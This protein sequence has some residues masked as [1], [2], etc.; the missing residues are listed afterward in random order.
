MA[1]RGLDDRRGILRT[2][3]DGAFSV[4]RFP[5]LPALEPYV[6]WAWVVAWD[7][8]GLPPHRQATLAH[9]SAHLV[10]EDGGVW[11]Y[12]PPRRRFETV[13]AG[14]GRTVAVR[15]R[16]GGARPLLDGP[17]AAIADRRV[18]APAGL[19]ADAVVAAVEREADAEAAAGAL[20]RALAPLLPARPDPAIALAD[21]AVALLAEDRSL[22]RVRQLA[23]RLGMSTRSLQRLFAEWVGV[24]AAWVVRRQRVQEAAAHALSGERVDWARL[25]AELG[26]V[27]QAHL[28]REFTAAVGVSPARYAAAAR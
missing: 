5:A 12:G 21:R 7:R 18:P 1:E 20:Q 10:V 24:G 6:A 8:R 17:V 22:V 19:D 9:P 11:L 4:A 3:R 28:V 2:P 27:D 13:L 23:E 16:P 15:F 25:A 26:Y 14:R